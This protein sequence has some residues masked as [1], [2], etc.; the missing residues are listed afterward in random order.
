MNIHD[1]KRRIHES[2]NEVLLSAHLK[3]CQIHHAEVSS[4]RF[5]DMELK[6]HE[7]MTLG[8]TFL[9]PALG[10]C[11]HFFT[12]AFVLVGLSDVS[13]T[14]NRLRALIVVILP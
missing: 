3:V 1:H 10:V 5:S 8:G 7:A 9:F 13:L 14:D 11:R 6:M 12:Q 4:L 2:R